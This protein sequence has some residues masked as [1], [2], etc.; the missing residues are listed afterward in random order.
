MLFDTI[1]AVTR[2]YDCLILLDPKWW[3]RETSWSHL[4]QQTKKPEEFITG[5]QLYW[6]SW[7]SGFGWHYL[8]R[9]TSENT[10]SQ[11][12]TAAFR[13]RGHG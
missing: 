12:P 11:K 1:Y 4:I 6:K 2:E 13:G 9:F 10:E 5:R 3:S 7:N 8:S